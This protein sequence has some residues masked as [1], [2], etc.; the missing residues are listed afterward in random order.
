MKIETVN[1]DEFVIKKA[2]RENE[3][4]LFAFWGPTGCGKTKSAL[5][6][7]DG[8]VSGTKKRIGMVDTEN[9]RGSH[10]ANEHDFDVLNMIDPYT[11]ERYLAA[12]LKFEKEG[13]GACIVDSMSHEWNGEGG[14]EDIQNDAIVRMCTKDGVFDAAKA[15]RLT[16]IAWKEPKRRHKRM[17]VRLL[18]RKMHIIFCLRAEQKVKF[19]K[20]KKQA[21]NGNTY[22]ANEIVDAGFLPIC[23]KGFMFEMTLSAKMLAKDSGGIPGVPIFS[24][25]EGQHE[26]AFSD[27]QIDVEAGALMAKWCR[28]ES[29]A[30]APEPQ[31]QKQPTKKTA[32]PKAD[33]PKVEEKPADPPK[34]ATPPKDDDFPGD[35]PMGSK[36]E[37]DGKY[38]IITSSKG[39]EVRT[40]DA[41][42]F[43]IGIISRIEKSANAAHL[44]AFMD[45]NK[46]NI[47]QLLEEGHGLM[48]R[49]IEKAVE[50]RRG[51]FDGGKRK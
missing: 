36:V 17:L 2:K 35:K 12:I 15:E 33:K 31:P 45:F 3:H 19:V 44:K 11:P 29:I 1:P 4:G 41:H 38:R 14:L 7:A 40:D 43:E 13:Y 32:E 25:I 27:K 23:E 24:K 46:D 37:G 42:A 39:D 22:E 51:E 50:K 16:A 47:A 48:F 5:I 8:L 18:Q 20:T 34:S 26:I 9:G 49:A 6:F 28:G 21:S 10:Y 30:A